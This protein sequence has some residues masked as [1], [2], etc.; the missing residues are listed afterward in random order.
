MADASV[1]PSELRQMV[2]LPQVAPRQ[3]QKFGARQEA[4]I[5]R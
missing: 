2:Y 1:S 4:D 3:Q 5:A